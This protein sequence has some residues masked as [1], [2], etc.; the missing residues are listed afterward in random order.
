[1]LTRKPITIPHLHVCS[2]TRR[3]AAGARAPERYPEAPP[4]PK[5]RPTADTWVTKEGTRIPVPDLGDT[6]LSNIL[7]WLDRYYT[8]GT[9]YNWRLFV[10]MREVRAGG[11]VGDDQGD[12]ALEYAEYL[13]VAPIFV[14]F[15]RMTPTLPALVDEAIKRGAERVT[16]PTAIR[17]AYDHRNDPPADE[18]EV[19]PYDPLDDVDPSGRYD[20]YGVIPGDE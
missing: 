6:H 14:V 20:N 2:F 16:I 3:V 15:A 7:G 5:P 4:V 17:A 1:M 10:G 8:S 11:G 18:P 13:M 19:P 12:A 9:H